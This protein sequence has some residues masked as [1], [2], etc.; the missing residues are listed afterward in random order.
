MPFGGK[1]IIMAF[2][3]EELTKEQQEEFNSWNVEC[4][5]Y[6]H[7]QEI[8]KTKMTDPWY[9]TVDKERNIYLLG[10]YNDRASLDEKLFV[11]IWNK[12]IY[13]VQFNKSFEDDNTVVWNI[14]KRYIIKN[15]FPYSTKEHFTDDL[16]SALIVYGIDGNNKINTKCNF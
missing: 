16:R 7:G 10:A 11:F 6:F 9:W 5:L 8:K 15:V 1:G 13:I 14:P 4:P 2:V 12:N 3:N